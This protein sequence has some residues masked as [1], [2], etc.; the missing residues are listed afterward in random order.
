M[1]KSRCRLHRVAAVHPILLERGSVCIVPKIG[2]IALTYVEDALETSEN[3]IARQHMITEPIP[4]AEWPRVEPIRRGGANI[5]S[6]AVARGRGGHD[7]GVGHEKA[8]CDMS[9]KQPKTTSTI[10]RPAVKPEED[11]LAYEMWLTGEVDH[12]PVEER[13][14]AEGLLREELQRRGPQSGQGERVRGRKPR[15]K[16][17]VS[18]GRR[19]FGD[20]RTA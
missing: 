14:A 6:L 16:R 15:D 11:P 13:A 3:K 4:R 19:T 10:A 5:V 12:D 18:G 20:M 8:R 9:Q 17:C 1:L 2:V 7:A